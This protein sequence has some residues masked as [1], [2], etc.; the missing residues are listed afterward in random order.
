MKKIWTR[1]ILFLKKDSLLS[2]LVF[3]VIAFVFIKWIFFPGLSLVLHTQYPIVA[4]ISGSMEHDELFDAWWTS[5]AFCG[6]RWCS[7][8]EFYGAFNISRDD[9]FSY[10]FNSG[11]NKGDIMLVTGWTEI[12]TGDVIVFEGSQ[13]YPIIHR[14]LVVTP[15]HLQTKGDN[16]ERQITFNSF[17]ETHVPRETVYGEAIIRVPYL[18]YVKIWFVNLLQFFGI[19]K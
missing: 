13:A 10:P 16:N 3:L 7:Q 14:A 11:F 5:N 19:L 6:N 2:T 15:T 17:D 12:S 1:C 8:S 4:V 9:F 18:G